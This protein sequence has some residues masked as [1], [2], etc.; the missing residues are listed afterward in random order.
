VQLLD[1]QVNVAMGQA[2]VKRWIDDLMPRVIADDDPLGLESFATDHV[3]LDEAPEA[4]E[5]FQK[6]QDGTFKV[7][8]NPERVAGRPAS[9]QAAASR[10]DSGIRTRPT[11]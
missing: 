10:A 6:K 7:V 9:A 11:G 8:I 3:S 2:N 5:R 4:Y 1:K